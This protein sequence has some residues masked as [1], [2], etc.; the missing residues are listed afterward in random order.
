MYCPGIVIS[1]ETCRVRRYTSPYIIPF[2]RSR[3]DPRNPY[4]HFPRLVA[5]INSV[6]LKPR[7]P[8]TKYSYIRNI[9][10]IAFEDKLSTSNRRA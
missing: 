8:P 6:K 10:S 5:L 4:R 7:N 3:L 1:L 9:R 2:V